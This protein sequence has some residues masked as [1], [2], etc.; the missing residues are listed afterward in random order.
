MKKENLSLDCKIKHSLCNKTCYH[1]FIN[2]ASHILFTRQQIPF[3]YTIIHN[4]KS[5]YQLKDV[6]KKLGKIY[7]DLEAIFAEIKKIFQSNLNQIDQFAMGIGS[8]STT[9]KG[10]K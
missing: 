5:G 8:S 9:L 6:E 1:V 10:Q 3:N 4:K 7:N 2:L